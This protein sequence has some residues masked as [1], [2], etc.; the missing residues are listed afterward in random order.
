MLPQLAHA[1]HILVQEI[2]WLPGGFV[3]YTIYLIAL[4]GFVLFYGIDRLIYR[5]WERDEL[6]NPNAFDSIVFWGDMILF[7]LYNSM[8]GY[9]V[10]TVNNLPDSWDLLIYFIAFSL[11][12]VTNDWSLHH[13]HRRAYDAYGRVILSVS[14][15]LGYLFGE[16]YQLPGYAVGLV[17]AF[18]TGALVLNAIK[19]EL[20]TEHEGN[21][22]GFLTRIVSAST[23]FFFL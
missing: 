4:L 6:Q 13:H 12:F 3:D 5:A 10:T 11:H 23:L 1:Q 15:L 21:F 22:E 2:G 14:I 17:E 8:I 7:G 16:F 19:Y 9:L 20:P 18:V